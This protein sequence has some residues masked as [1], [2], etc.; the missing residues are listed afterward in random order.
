[1]A[2]SVGTTQLADDGVTAAKLA[3]GCIDAAAKLASDVVTTAKILDANV[4]NG[5]LA[6]DAATADKISHDNNARKTLL[7]F[8]LGAT[9]GFG[10]MG[11]LQCALG[12][13]YP[14]PH[15]GFITALCSSQADGT[16]YRDSQ[17]YS[18]SG[19]AGD[20][21]FVQDAVIS[22]GID[23]TGQLVVVRINATVVT[24]LNACSWDD[25]QTA[26]VVVELEFDD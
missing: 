6:A 16:T 25:G 18:A 26:A 22:V 3:D 21:R 7:T 2:G 10:Y 12:L 1:V 19:S 4:T 23:N 11:T 15:A 5:K 17:A 24:A 13:G 14:M 20:G 9:A 8:T